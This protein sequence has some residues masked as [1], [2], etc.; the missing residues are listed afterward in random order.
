MLGVH[1]SAAL[2]NAHRHY[3]MHERTVHPPLMASLVGAGG[4]LLHLHALLLHLFE[5]LDLLSHVCL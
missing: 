4:G 5:C 1:T 2:L 3:L